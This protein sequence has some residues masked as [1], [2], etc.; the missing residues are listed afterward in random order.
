MNEA[1][2]KKYTYVEKMDF[3]IPIKKI[4]LFRICY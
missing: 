3:V 1:E 4:G 2:E